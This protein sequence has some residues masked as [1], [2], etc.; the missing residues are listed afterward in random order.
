M[1]NTKLQHEFIPF[2]QTE[3]LKLTQSN[4]KFIIKNDDDENIEYDDGVSILTTEKVVWFSIK[5]KKGI[6]FAYQNAITHGYSGLKLVCIM[7]FTN[8]EEVGSTGVYGKELIENE[9]NMIEEDKLEEETDFVLA[10]LKNMDNLISFDN[11]VKIVGSYEIH[12]DFSKSGR[13]NI[14]DL[15]RVFS[16]CSALNPDENPDQNCNFFGLDPNELFTAEN[17]DENGN[18][19]LKEDEEDNEDNDEENDDNE[20]EENQIEENEDINK[21]GLEKGMEFE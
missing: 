4:V 6:Y 5:E 12:F 2:S 3:E 18:L 16:E 19:I 21:N 14:I 10:K 20:I 13:N 1:E 17:I 7:N 15:F 8:E 9:E 11:F